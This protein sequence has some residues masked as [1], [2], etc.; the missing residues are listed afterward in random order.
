MFWRLYPLKDFRGLPCS[1]FNFLFS[2]IM[3]RRKLIYLFVIGLATFLEIVILYFIILH[4]VNCIIVLQDYLFHF[5]QESLY[6]LAVLFELFIILGVSSNCHQLFYCLPELFY[7][8]I[9]FILIYLLFFLC[10]IFWWIQIAY[11]LYLLS[12]HI[13]RVEELELNN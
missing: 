3:I 13:I 6:Y 1:K 9:P 5:L 7:F 4:S 2:P 12:M 10:L 8:F 11:F